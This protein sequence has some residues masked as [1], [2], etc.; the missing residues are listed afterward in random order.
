[1]SGLRIIGTKKH[2][3]S[4]TRLISKQRSTYR[5]RDNIPMHE[6]ST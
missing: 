1:V 2:K 3:G 6:V 4:K 5:E